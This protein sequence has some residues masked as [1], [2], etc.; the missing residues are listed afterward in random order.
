MWRRFRRHRLALVGLLIIAL[1]STMALLRP[2]V[3][4]HH[5]NAVDLT[6]FKNAPTLPFIHGPLSDSHIMGTDEAGRDIYARI[7]EAGRISLTVGLLAS[8]VSAVIGTIIGMVSGYAGGKTDDIL[9]RFTELVMTFPSFFAMIILVA[10][11]G[12]NMINLIAVI[13]LLGWPGKARL[14]RGQVLSIREMDYVMAAK[15]LGASG[16]RQIFVHILPGIMGY[17]AVAAMLTIAGAILAEAGLSFLG[18]GVQIPQATW[19]N[20]MT[21]AQSMFI[22]ENNPWIW[23][24]PGFAISMTVIAVNFMGDGLRDALDPR[25]RIE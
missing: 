20:M 23:L 6:K 1:F 10:L 11:V 17:V 15:A 18:L 8:A 12:P 7:V 4:W 3:T 5:P 9:M 2:V 25:T 13:G 22:L 24:P 21:S 16:G 19:G 14:V